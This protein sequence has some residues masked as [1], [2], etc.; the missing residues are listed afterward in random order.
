MTHFAFLANGSSV[1]IFLEER[2]KQRFKIRSMVTKFIRL[3]FE[4]IEI[5]GEKY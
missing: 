5:E 4:I 1:P 3:R 2:E